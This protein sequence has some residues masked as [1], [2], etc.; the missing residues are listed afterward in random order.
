LAAACNDPDHRPFAIGAKTG[1][2]G[3]PTEQGGRT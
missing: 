2:N 3:R 1:D